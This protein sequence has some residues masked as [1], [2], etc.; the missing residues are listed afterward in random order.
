MSEHTPGPWTAGKDAVF[1]NGHHL[2]VATTWGVGGPVDRATN[3]ANTH[4][5]AAAPDMLRALVELNCII[6]FDADFS[7]CPCFPAIEG[8]RNAARMA[9]EAIDAARGKAPAHDELAKD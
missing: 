3:D 8:L 4:L 1:A 6:D 9:R 5:I 7:E 2:V